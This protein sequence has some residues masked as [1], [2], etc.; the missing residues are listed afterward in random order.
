MKK[1]MIPILIVCSSLCSCQN[2]SNRPRSFAEAQGLV[3]RT[4][5]RHPEK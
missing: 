2:A 4:A 5:A 1:L 3:E